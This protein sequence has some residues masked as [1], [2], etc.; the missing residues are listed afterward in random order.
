MGG[1]G[2]GGG[3][4]GVGGVVIIDYHTYNT[5]PAISVRGQLRFPPHV[6]G[7]ME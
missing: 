6:S 3:G 2:G 5:D 7:Q 4:G 1:G